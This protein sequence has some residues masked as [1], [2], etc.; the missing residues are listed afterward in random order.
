MGGDPHCVFILY[1]KNMKKN[2]LFKW[3]SILGAVLLLATSLMP[4]AFA[5]D[6]TDPDT[7]WGW[8]G[9][10]G[11]T[12]KP[13][14]VVDCT[15][16]TTSDDFSVCI[17]NWS[18]ITI[19]NDIDF[20]T[21]A[22]FG[23]SSPVA[24]NWWNHTFTDKITL[25][26]SY[27][28]LQFLPG[29]EWSKIENLNF[30]I[31]T[32]NKV[33]DAAAIFFAEGFWSS[34]K[35][36]INNISVKWEGDGNRVIWID[37]AYN[38]EWNIKITQSNFE[39]IMY[40]MYFNWIQNVEISDNTINWTNYNAINFASAPKNIT[41]KDNTFENIS[42]LENNTYGDQYSAWIYL[43]NGAE[44]IEIEGNTII[45][46]YGDRH[47]IFI[48]EDNLLP[49]S[50]WTFSDDVSDYT[51]DGKCSIK[52]DDWKYEVKDCPKPS[53]TFVTSKWTELPIVYDENKTIKLAE[54]QALF[55]KK[56]IPSDPQDAAILNAIK[57]AE[58]LTGTEIVEIESEDV[59]FFD[60]SAAIPTVKQ[61]KAFIKS[62][63]NLFSKNAFKNG[64]TDTGNITY[65]IDNAINP[66]W[67]TPNIEKVTS[68]NAVSK[69]TEI[70]WYT[71]NMDDEGDWWFYAPRMYK[72]T[73]DTNWGAENYEA[74]KVALTEWKATNPWIPTK[75]WSWFKFWSLSNEESAIEYDFSAEVT[76]D[77][78]LY[79]IYGDDAF[80]IT[81]KNWNDI[82]NT[83]AFASWA[84]PAYVWDTPSKDADSTCNTYEFKEWDPS[85]TA[86]TDETTYTAT[87]TC[88]SP[89]SSKSSWGWGG[90]GSSKVTNTEDTKATTWDTAK[91]D[92]NNTEEN[93]EEKANDENKDEE[94]APMTDAQAVEKFGQEQ[95][96]AYKWALE[97]GI[98][99]MKTVEAARLDEPL[100]R[101]ELAKMMVVYI[102][103]VLEKDPIVTG[104]VTYPDVD[105]SL[106]D[107]YGYIKLAYQY[108]I[109]GINADGTPIKFFNPNGLVTR[110]EYATVFSRVLF[111]DKF[112]KAGED[113]Y[114]KHLEALKAAWILT[115]TIPTIQ[116]MR[117]WVMLMM[118]RS[119]QNSEAIENVANTSETNEEEKP[120]E[121]TATASDETKSEANEEEKAEEAT[122][123]EAPTGDTAEA[124]TW[125]VAETPTAEA[126]TWDTASN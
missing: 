94:K 12:N 106:G 81:W 7:N 22:R 34:E 13:A 96:D 115:N 62:G 70:I 27:S 126:N 92:E 67:V 64:S 86:V 77:I 44:N 47:S 101:A 87:F 66:S 114:T 74:Q 50:S 124:T 95:I 17:A 125:D 3:V 60:V 63:S 8:G 14:T 26:G 82:I 75:Q 56:P 21:N 117:G 48:K 116:E 112:N 121:E 102:Q 42:N 1:T 85:V 35:T 4:V 45:M 113:F 123:A 43:W 36:E 68:Y 54:T 104:D 11:W 20:G 31:T 15:N 49:I 16:V 71:L 59:L 108:Q 98:T 91:V 9:G 72:I 109:M 58:E 89:K 78:T 39:N 90:G 10:W 107:L 51:A 23:I 24:I 33:Y 38:V 29:S 53:E 88:T 61:T 73:F 120:D 55:K 69:D 32:E 40:W 110:W 6:P 5:D 25:S 79:A 83:G 93:N 99:T 18:E 19:W 97:N 41:I 118:Y 119:S 57:A 30:E 28:L 100:T 65:D 105:E 37:S 84:M 103:K 2:S 46:A 122:N 111:W 80:T 76:G 52:N